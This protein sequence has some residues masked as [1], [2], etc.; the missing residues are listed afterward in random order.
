MSEVKAKKTQNVSVQKDDSKMKTES[1]KSG[2]EKMPLKGQAAKKT[3]V[4]AKENAKP[5]AQKKEKKEKS[6]FGK[7]A[8]KL[9]ELIRRKK[10]PVFR[11]RFGA[12]WKRKK[13]NPKWNK[14]RYPRGIDIIF[15]NEDGANPKIGYRVPK[16]IRFLHPSGMHEM[17]VATIDELPKFKGE[18]VAIR[19]A[20]R[21]GKR[22]RVLMLKKAD[23]FG[24]KV[25]NRWKK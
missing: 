23:E 2:A 15:K 10:H 13:S 8:M 18:N 12:R 4:D 24:L 7:K 21:I 20:S 11:G 9:R 3:A 14:W 25:L 6:A 1:K 22:K 19:F 5:V 17:T 16:D